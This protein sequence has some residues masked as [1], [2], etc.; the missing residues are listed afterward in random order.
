[1]LH[2]RATSASADTYIVACVE[3]LS[4]Q[5]P[6]R[7]SAIYCLCKGSSSAWFEVQGSIP[8]PLNPLA[9]P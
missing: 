5:A 4:L 7:P 3:F 6:N 1:M 9:W 2:Q 8:Q